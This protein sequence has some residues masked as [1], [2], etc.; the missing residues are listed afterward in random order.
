MRRSI[1]LCLLL[2]GCDGHDSDYIPYS[3]KGMDVWVYDE[4]KDQSHF[5]GRVD[6]SYFSGG[7]AR[8]ECHDLAIYYTRANP[9]IRRWG[10]V[11]CTVTSSSSC[12]TK[13]R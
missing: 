5:A 3:L 1:V 12:Y 9:Q 6:A 11:C 13:V 7:K 4:D 2:V 8:R 10:W